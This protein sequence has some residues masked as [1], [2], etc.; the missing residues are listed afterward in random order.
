MNHRSI[1]SLLL[2]PALLS[3]APAF[4]AQYVCTVTS[5]LGLNDSGQ[6]VTHEWENFYLNRRFVVDRDQG[7]VIS[8]TALKARLKNFD[9]N[10]DPKLLSRGDAVHPFLSVSI[11][12][13]TAEYAALQI[14]E[15]VA[16]EDKPFYYQTYI[17]MLMAGT[18]I[19]DSS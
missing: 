13:K 7:K 19:G 17:G 15:N 3:P 1:I 2:L 12:E 10:N 16:G 11:F 9:E 18:C 8:T 6:Y 4:A 5:V 14:K